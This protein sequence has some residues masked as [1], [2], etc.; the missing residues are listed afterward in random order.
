MVRPVSVLD[1]TGVNQVI[2]LD[3][4]LGDQSPGE[5]IAAQSP[6]PLCGKPLY[7]LRKFGHLRAP[8]V[9]FWEISLFPPSFS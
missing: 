3:M 5:G 7:C 6:R 9:D 4:M 8:E 2:D 1:K